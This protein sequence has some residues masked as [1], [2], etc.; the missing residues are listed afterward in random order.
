MSEARAKRLPYL[1]IEVIII[2]A[3]TLAMIT[4]LDKDLSSWETV[5]ADETG[6][7]VEVT[8]FTSEATDALLIIA[9][10]ATAGTIVFVRMLCDAV[11]FW[12]DR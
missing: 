2:A 5:R 7:L 1:V 8:V 11:W 9:V 10:A 12:E 4:A 3:C 6:K